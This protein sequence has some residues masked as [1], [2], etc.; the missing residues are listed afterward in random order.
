VSPYFRG[1]WGGD[2]LLST[3]LETRSPNS[4]RVVGRVQSYLSQPARRTVEAV[5]LYSESMARFDSGSPF[6]YPLYG[7]GELPQ[8]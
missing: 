7:L 1:M 2:A 5:Q 8:V 4:R 6:L 3:L